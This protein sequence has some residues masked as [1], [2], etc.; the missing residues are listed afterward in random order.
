MIF[1]ELVSVVPGYV[2]VSAWTTLIKP[3]VE[4]F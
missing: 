1:T 2:F 4:S 3:G